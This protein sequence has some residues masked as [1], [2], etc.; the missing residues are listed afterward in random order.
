[1]SVQSFSGHYVLSTL[2]PHPVTLPNTTVKKN[3]SKSPVLATT[4]NMAK[5]LLTSNPYILL[6]W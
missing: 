2:Q 1:M 3:Q 5:D 4:V 6:G